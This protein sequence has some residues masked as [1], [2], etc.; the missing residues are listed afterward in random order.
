L[1][2][3][4]HFQSHFDAVLGVVGVGHGHAGD[5]VVAVAQDLDPHALMLVGSVVEFAEEVVER[6]HQLLHG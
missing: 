6:L 4:N 3:L 1:L 2:Y 5:A